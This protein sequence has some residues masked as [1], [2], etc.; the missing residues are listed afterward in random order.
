[1]AG[2]VLGDVGETMGSSGLGSTAKLP[3]ELLETDRER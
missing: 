1:M 2:R 3:I